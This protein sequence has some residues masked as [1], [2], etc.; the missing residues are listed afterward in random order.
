MRSELGELLGCRRLTSALKQASKSHLAWLQAP[1]ARVRARRGCAQRLGAQPRTPELAQRVVRV[2]GRQERNHLHALR[3]LGWSQGRVHKLLRGTQSALTAFERCPIGRTRATGRRLTRPTVSRV[4]SESE[5]KFRPPSW[6]APP[7]ARAWLEVR[8]T[9]DDSAPPLS[10]VPL[11]A[12]HATF[13]RGGGDVRVDDRRAERLRRASTRSFSAHATPRSAASR[14]HAALVHHQDGKWYLIDLGASNGTLVDGF[15]AQ[16]H[17]PLRL[18]PGF[19]IRFGGDKAQLVYTLHTEEG[20]VTWRGLT[21]SE[22]S[23]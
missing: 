6:S 12:P 14:L 18:R 23:H 10:T 16:K 2:A 19:G 22:D 1:A 8:R 20:C 5:V 3:V 9:G 13:G 21:E 11:D 17:R 7:R 15:A 4:M